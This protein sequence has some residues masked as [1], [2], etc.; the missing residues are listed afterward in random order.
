MYTNIKIIHALFAIKRQIT[1]QFFNLQHA[2]MS[3]ELFK[4]SQKFTYK[5]MKQNY[6]FQENEKNLFRQ[7]A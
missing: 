3:K 7:C 2:L 4:K 5:N 1:A 6:V